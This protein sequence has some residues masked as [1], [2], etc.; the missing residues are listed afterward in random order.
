MTQQIALI[1][2]GRA[3]T[4]HVREHLP[5]VSPDMLTRLKNLETSDKDQIWVLQER[6]CHRFSVAGTMEYDPTRDE[7]RITIVF[8]PCVAHRGNVEIGGMSHP[9]HLSSGQVVWW[10][11]VYAHDDP[12]DQ[13]A[14]QRPVIVITADGGA[15]HDVR[16]DRLALAPEGVNLYNLTLSS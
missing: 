11:K 15:R 10:H 1:E 8:I 16:L 13:I 6:I 4:W 9:H 5:P 12:A 2:I 7:D 14:L 3:P